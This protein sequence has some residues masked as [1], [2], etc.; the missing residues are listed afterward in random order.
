MRRPTTSP[1]NYFITCWFPSWQEGRR[2][3]LRGR[4]VTI[5]G[6]RQGFLPLLKEVRLTGCSL[7]CA[8]PLLLPI[9][10]QQ[11]IFRKLF[12]AP[13]IVFQEQ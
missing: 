11:I 3:G 4:Q 2:A 13:L 9:P 1:S 6:R 12:P 10:L 5:S 8:S 7:D